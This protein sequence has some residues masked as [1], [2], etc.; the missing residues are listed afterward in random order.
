MEITYELQDPIEF[1]GK[2][3]NDV[4]RSIESLKL[5]SPTAR[6][7]SDLERRGLLKDGNE[8]QM[9]F[10]VVKACAKLDDLAADR[11]SIMDMNGAMEAMKKAG[12]FP[13]AEQPTTKPTEPEPTGE[14]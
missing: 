6:L 14:E 7:F 3:S 4:Q 9:S 11:L 1:V 5:R 12:F 8:T 2:K 13:S 10:E